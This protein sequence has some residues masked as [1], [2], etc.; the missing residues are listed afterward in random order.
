MSVDFVRGAWRARISVNRKRIEL[1]RF[2]TETEARAAYQT[3]LDSHAAARTRRTKPGLPAKERFLAKCLP[4]TNGC[5]MWTG[6]KDKDGYGK[7]QLNAGGS[8]RHV[9]AHRFAFF[10]AHG[11]WPSRLALHACDTPACVNAN[12]IANGTQSENLEQCAS[13]GRRKSIQLTPDMVRVVR[14]R[15]QAGES[16]TVIAAEIGI[17]RNTLFAVVHRRTWRHVK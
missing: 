11:Q 12:H 17:S 16:V 13:R 14:A 5:I 8:Q 2:P 7:F 4:T 6:A 10:L 15:H 9:R 3:A 1:G